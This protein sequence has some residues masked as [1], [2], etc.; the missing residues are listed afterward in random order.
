MAFVAIDFETANG[1]RSSACS[2]GVVVFDRHSIIHEW[3]TL[4]NPED[5]FDPFNI[6]IH[7]IEPRHVTGAPT[8]REF[9]RAIWPEFQ[10]ATLVA[11]SGVDRSV[12][13][14]L[15]TMSGVGVPE[16]TWLDSCDIARTIWS[17]LPDHKL[18]TVCKRLRFAFRHHNALE[19]AR[20]CSFI[21][22]SAMNV[23]DQD[24]DAFRASFSRY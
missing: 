3:H 5:T 10:G 8:T 1:R 14:A 15:S 24:A 9:V 11:H 6:A 22:Q 7:G 16:A 13:N 21:V 20:A 17:D 23:L 19:D 12:I 2:V 4:L 18:K